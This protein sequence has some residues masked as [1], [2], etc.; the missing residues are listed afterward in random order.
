ML[1][2]QIYVY[3]GRSSLLFFFFLQTIVTDMLL[4]FQVMDLVVKENLVLE[5]RRMSLSEFHTADEVWDSLFAFPPFV[6]IS[7]SKLR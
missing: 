6:S 5:E 4:L 2:Q 3:Y 1:W 7:E